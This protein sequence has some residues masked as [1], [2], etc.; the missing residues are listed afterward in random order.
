MIEKMIK[1]HMEGI[2]MTTLT[3]EQVL[4]QVKN[5]SMDEEIP[6]EFKCLGKIDEVYPNLPKEVLEHYRT[7]IWEWKEL[8]LRIATWD[9]GNGYCSFICEGTPDELVKHLGEK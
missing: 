9:C 4:E 1:F 5:I 3:K 7:W 8:D 6:G 2:F